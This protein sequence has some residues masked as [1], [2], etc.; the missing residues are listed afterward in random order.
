MKRLPG[1]D[2]DCWELLQGQL[3]QFRVFRRGLLEDGNVGVGA[4]PECEEI[5]ICH[6]SLGSVA[7]QDIGA[8][9]AEMGECANGFVLHNA[10]VV[11]DFLELGCGFAALTGG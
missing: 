11:E 6:L 9:K 2:R 10:A 3:L 5:L 4:F 1:T 8:S 7:L